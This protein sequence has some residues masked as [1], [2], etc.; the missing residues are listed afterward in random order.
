MTVLPTE[1]A[2]ALK[3]AKTVG[4]VDVAAEWV[5]AQSGLPNPVTYPSISYLSTSLISY[6]KQLKISLEQRLG[7]DISELHFDYMK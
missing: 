5:F 4:A 6:L 2:P 1:V 7:S 3:R